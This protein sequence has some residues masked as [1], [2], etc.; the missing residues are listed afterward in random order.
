MERVADTELLRRASRGDGDAYEAFYRRHVAVVHAW[1]LRRTGD[2][3]VAEDL[4]AETFAAALCGVRRFRGE[5]DQAAA[6]WLYAIAGHE[7]GRFLQQRSAGDACR[8]TL[9]ILLERDSSSDLAPPASDDLDEQLERALHSLPVQQ[10][11][12]IRLRVLLELDYDDVG[13]ELDCSATTARQRA[14]RALGQLRRRLASG[15]A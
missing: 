3:E 12:V 5:H 14:A 8:R 2:H 4:A 6:A 15:E 7:L 9:G 1:F 11:R 13:R 10:Q